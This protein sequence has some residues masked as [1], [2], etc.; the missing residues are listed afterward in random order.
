MIDPLTIYLAFLKIG[1]LAFGGAYAGMPLIEQEVV[2]AQQWMTYKEFTDL[3][4][5]DELTPGPIIINSA[6]YIGMKLGGLSGAIAATL[7]SI[8]PACI[9]SFILICIYRRY[10]EIPLISEMIN[11]L[12]CMSI[13]LIL[14]TVLKIFM[15][16]VFPENGISYLSIIMILLSFYIIRRSKL[17]PIYVMLGC[18]ALRLLV[19]FIVK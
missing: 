10:K 14:S 18:G 7:G 12:K 6:T 11:I 4:A 16:A 17:N 1:A 3:I 2:K 8:T 5:I 15:N 9:V 19:S 13:A